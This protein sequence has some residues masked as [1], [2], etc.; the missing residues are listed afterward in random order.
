MEKNSKLHSDSEIKMMN[1][2]S[3]YNAPIK[4]IPGGEN[5]IADLLSRPKLQA[6]HIWLDEPIEQKKFMDE[7]NRCPQ[8]KTLQE[9]K[10]GLTMNIKKIDGILYDVLHGLNRAI[11]PVSLRKK[12]FDQVHNLGHVGPKRTL[13]LIRTRFVWPSMNKEIRHWA[14]SCINCQDSYSG[15]HPNPYL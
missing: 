11:V 7:Q 1:Y 9:N 12:I 8:L 14:K 2:I 13:E 4:H 5:T 6:S 15:S 3:T 10:H